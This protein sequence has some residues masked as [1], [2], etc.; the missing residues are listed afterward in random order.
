MIYNTLAALSL[1]SLSL[2]SGKIYF[3]EDFN[4]ASWKSRWTVPTGWKSEVRKIRMISYKR[5]RYREGGMEEDKPR[6][7]ERNLSNGSDLYVG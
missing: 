3:K 2:V 5:R 6:E 7:I 4:D 1:T